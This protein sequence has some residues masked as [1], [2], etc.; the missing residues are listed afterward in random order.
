MVAALG[1]LMRVGLSGSNDLISVTKEMDF[2]QNYLYMHKIRYGEIFQFS[3]EYPEEISDYKIIKFLLQPIVENAVIHGLNGYEGAGII[4]VTAEKNEDM[5]CFAVRDNGCGMSSGEK[6]AL[7]DRLSTSNT[8][9]T[10]H[11]GLKNIYD[12]I[13]LFYGERGQLLIESKKGEGTCVQVMIPAML[14][15]DYT[16]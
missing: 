12:R 2:I 14:G 6:E 5:L 8:R 10:N 3:V 16:N 4:S 1:K 15:N 9:L 13:K 11:I 7:T